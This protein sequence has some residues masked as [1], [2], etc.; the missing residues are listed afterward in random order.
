M[1]E[2]S[3]DNQ[4]PINFMMMKDHFREEFIKYFKSVSLFPFF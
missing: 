2:D 1:E 3:S 4:A